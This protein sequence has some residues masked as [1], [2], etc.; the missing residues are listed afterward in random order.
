M[1]ETIP[2][3][4]HATHTSG[5]SSGRSIAARIRRERARSPHQ[6]RHHGRFRCSDLSF[7]AGNYPTVL[8]DGEI[9]LHESTSAT[10]S[11]AIFFPIQMSQP[12]PTE[13]TAL[14]RDDIAQIAR[15]IWTESGKPDGRD[16]AIW[17][18]AERRL[19][20]AQNAVA[21]IILPAPPPTSALLP[22]LTTA[23][24]LPPARRV[25]PRA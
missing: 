23:R 16:L 25:R 5:S 10:Q 3:H 19:N 24:V 9:D 20:S 17:L 12:I 7:K 6:V 21:A 14:L 1:L 2:R 11:S 13:A 8:D 22:P 18:E 15:E 4:N